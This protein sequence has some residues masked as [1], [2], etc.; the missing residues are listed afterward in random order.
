[1]QKN[2]SLN[3]LDICFS[4]KNTKVPAIIIKLQMPLS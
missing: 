3:I 4:K 2:G 1:M